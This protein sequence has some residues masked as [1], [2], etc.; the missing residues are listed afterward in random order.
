[1]EYDIYKVGGILIRDRKL[2]VEKSFGKDFYLAP[3][4]KVEPGEKAQQALVRELK[5]EFEIQVAE[6]DL[7]AFGTF[8]AVAAG[9]DDKKIRMDVFMVKKW[10]GEPQP[11]SEVER[12]RWIES[13]ESEHLAV[14][15]VIKHEIIPRLKEQNLI[16]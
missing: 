9:Q 16:D 8:Y 1:M 5:E 7:E 3:G 13:H 11:N 12:I 4:G 15:S 2:L 6:N 10:N 14:G